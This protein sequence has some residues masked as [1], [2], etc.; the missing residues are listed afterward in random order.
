MITTNQ[1]DRLRRSLLDW[2]EQEGRS[3]PWRIRPEARAAGQIADPYTVWLS[4]IMLQQTTIPHAT[5]YWTRF[6]KLWPHVKDLAAAQRDDVLREWAGLGYYARARNLHA[7]AII[8]ATEFD[9]DFPDTLEALLALPGIGDYTANAILAAAFDKPASVVDG[10]V[11]RVISRFC[12][13]AT[14]LPKAKA[15]IRKIAGSLADPHRSGDYAQA[16][17]DLGATVCSPRKPDCGACPWNA[18]CEAHRVGDAERF[19]LKTKKK[20]R[21]VRY[22]TAWL[23]RQGDHVW[24][25]QRSDEGLL[26][27]MMEVPSTGWETE[28][29]EPSPPFDST[30]VRRGEVKHIFTHFELRLDVQETDVSPDWVSGV[31]GWVAPENL[32]RQ[33]LP[34]VMRKVITL[35]R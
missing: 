21:P 10:N 20:P 34:T 29:A 23:I 14:P 6:L 25:Q 31:G 27:G 16:I 13:V 18:M 28:P 3:L 22:G 17:M 12:R 7:C 19:P 33:A 2:Y 5:P 8:I 9:G 15:E 35:M 11:E 4:E 24:L 32:G 30:W 1:T 26:G